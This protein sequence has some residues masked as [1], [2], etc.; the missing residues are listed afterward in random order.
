MELKPFTYI[1]THP[2]HT[3]LYTGV[4]SQPVQRIYQHKNKTVSGFTQRYNVIKLVYYELHQTMETAILREKQ[5]KNLVR[6][7]KIELINKFNP[8]W[9]DLYNE[10]V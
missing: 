8:E 6:R 1:L 7:K 4:T 10:I 9:K 3:V 5:I 2:I